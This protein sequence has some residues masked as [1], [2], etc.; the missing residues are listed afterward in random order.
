MILHSIVPQEMIFPSTP[1]ERKFYKLKYGYAEISK[2]SGELKNINSTNPY[3]YL[4]N[5]SNLYAND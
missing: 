3:D 2:T 1:D 4:N 5:L